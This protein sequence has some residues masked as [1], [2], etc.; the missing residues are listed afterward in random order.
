[1]CIRDRKCTIAAVQDFVGYV[2]AEQKV[3]R[4]GR[5]LH[6]IIQSDHLSH[7]ASAPAVAAE[8]QDANTV[9]YISPNATPGTRIAREASMIDVYATTLELTGLSAAPVAA[10]LGR[11]LLSAPKTLREEHGRAR[12]DDLFARDGEIAAKVWQ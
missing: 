6:I 1:M 3:K 10:N 4:P 5:P 7:N 12:L 9:I 8:F 2:Q 11:S